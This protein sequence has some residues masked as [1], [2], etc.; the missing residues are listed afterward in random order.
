M[1]VVATGVSGT[2]TD[3][4][5]PT[6]A[7]TTPAVGELIVIGVCLTGNTNTSTISC[8][9]DQGGTYAKINSG[10]FNSSTGTFAVF[11]RQQSVAS[12]S[13]HNVTISN[14]STNTANGVIYY[15]VSGVTQTGSSAVRQSGLQQNGSAVT[16][17]SVSLGGAALT[18][19]ILIGFCFNCVGSTTATSPPTGFTEDRDVASSTAPNMGIEAAHADSGITASTITWGSVLTA[20]YG[21]SVLEL[22]T[23]NTGTLAVTLGDTTLAATG[24]IKIQGTSSPTL[25]DASLTTATAQLKIQGTLGVTLDAVVADAE[26]RAIHGTLGVTLDDVSL[27]DAK[28]LRQNVY[29]WPSQ[30]IVENP[31]LG[32][33]DISLS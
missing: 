1:G 22:T 5:T 2:S 9:D 16:T 10:L 26:I 23:Q 4:Q 3:N 21:A 15:R 7:V 24:T 27:G 20:A 18:N 11:V 28:F 29:T 13:T 8:A 30:P 33:E 25:A 6:I 31:A 17:P 32:E 14:V 12:T 19:N